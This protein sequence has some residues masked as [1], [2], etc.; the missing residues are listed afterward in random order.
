MRK[1]I[2]LLLSWL[3]Q[4]VWGSMT[5][6]WW[7]WPTNQQ[8]SGASPK[9]VP[10]I[11][12][13]G[14]CWT[15]VPCL[16]DRRLF[17]FISHSLTYLNQSQHIAVGLLS[18]PCLL[19]GDCF[20]PQVINHSTGCCWTAIPVPCHHWQAIVLIMY[21]ITAWCCWTSQSPVSVYRRLFFLLCLLLFHSVRS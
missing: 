16:L 9:V 1:L 10:T 21:P 3:N 15:P 6:R 18:V 2:A 7:Q 14:S 13:R 20:S 5:V 8:Q 11:T 19:T 17:F 4:V 12:A